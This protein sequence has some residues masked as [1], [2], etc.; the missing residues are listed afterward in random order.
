MIP[1][2]QASNE[3]KKDECL[4]GEPRHRHQDSQEDT[5]TFENDSM[6][7]P[8]DRVGSDFSW[9]QV[10]SQEDSTV[11]KANELED[12]ESFLYGNEDNGPHSSKSSSAAFSQIGEHGKLQ[13]M[14][15]LAISSQQHHQNK[16]VFSN[17]EDLLVVK[18]PLEMTSSNIASANMDSIE[19]EKI[20]TILKSLGTVDINEITVNVQGPTEAKQSQPALLLSSDSTAVGLALP[21]LSDPNV[22]QALES[23][24]SLI[25]G[26][27]PTLDKRRFNSVRGV[28]V[29]LHLPWF[30]MLCNPTVTD[31]WY[32]LI[33][34]KPD[35][36]AG[37]S[38][39]L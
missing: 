6:L 21:A 39:Q 38:L 37:L 25:K 15:S 35:W 19:S 14:N 26:E 31:V 18:Q 29:G 1:S 2:V 17:F 24:Q 23:L 13:E 30:S 4:P 10:P 3:S 20:K 16:S 11:Q 22:R 36:R 34:T 32:V 5:R 7:L 8:H 9:L 12:E 33:R 28:V 27:N